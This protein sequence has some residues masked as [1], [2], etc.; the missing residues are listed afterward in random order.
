MSGESVGTR[1]TTD[2]FE[3]LG[4]HDS[5]VHGLFLRSDQSTWTSDFILDI[6]YILRWICEENQPYRFLVAPATLVFHGMSEFAIKSANI[7]FGELFEIDRIDREKI[8]EF[9]YLWTIV[10]H[11]SPE[12]GFIKFQAHGFTQ[13][14]RQTPIE[15]DEQTLDTSQRVS[16]L[17]EPFD[18]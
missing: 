1:W 4:W 10:L 15:S 3:E 18:P 9:T 8:N 5:N 2:D 11:G 13:T 7:C 17:K 14:L 16:L 6:D 12:G